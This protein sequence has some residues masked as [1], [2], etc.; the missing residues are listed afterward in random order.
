[1]QG[2]LNERR[3]ALDVAARLA[4]DEDEGAIVRAPD[5]R[6]VSEHL[7]ELLGTRGLRQHE[8]RHRVPLVAI[9]D[10]RNAPFTVEARAR[11]DELEASPRGILREVR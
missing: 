10:V 11:T 7:D 3:Q 5:R 6:L 1:M 2:R 9:H 8:E 4:R